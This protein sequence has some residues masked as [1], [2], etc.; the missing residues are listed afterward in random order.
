[1][2]YL[3]FFIPLERGRLKKSSWRFKW[4]VGFN[5]GLLHKNG[6]PKTLN[7]CYLPGLIFTSL[8][9]SILMIL[10]VS[11]VMTIGNILW[12]ILHGKYI[13]KL[14]DDSLDLF[15]SKKIPVVSCD[16]IV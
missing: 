7:N 3:F 12:W 10:V 8:V 2:V 5:S 14:S 15:E 1:M 4:L 11:I 16:R 6:K 13:V 9:W